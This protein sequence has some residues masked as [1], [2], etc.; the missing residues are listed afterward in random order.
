MKI[1]IGTDHRGIDIKNKIIEHFKGEYD[2][3]DKSKNAFEGDD[4]PDYAFAVAEAVK[5][6]EADFGVLMCGTGIGMSIA[7]NK[8]KGIRCALIHSKEEAKLARI[9]N[10]ANI[11]SFGSY[12][13]IEDIYEFI[14]TF[15][16]TNDN[17]EERHIRRV[18]K[19]KEYENRS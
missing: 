17:Q 7:A 3:I 11:I 4:Y 13:D 16:E 2:F 8:V 9:H 5:N 15:I 10:D 14:K 19:I 1:A 12:N 18:N 6:K